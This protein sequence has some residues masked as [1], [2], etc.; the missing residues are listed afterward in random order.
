MVDSTEKTPVFVILGATGSV[1]GELTR[2]LSASGARLMLG[3]RDANALINAGETFSSPV[4]NIDAHAPETIE[5]CI[6]TA[7]N[8]YGRIDGIVNC[9][10]SLIL[11]SAHATSYQ[12]WQET[13][14]V[15]L[16]SAFA[17]VRMAGKLM[18]QTGG[19][20]ILIS[21]AAART[22]LANHEAIAAAKAGVI[23]LTLSAAATYA[24][25]GIR[26]NAIAPGLIKS[27]MTRKIWEN[28]SA[29]SASIAMH[30]LQR[31]GEPRDVASLIEWLLQPENNWITGQIIGVDGG[32]SSIVQKQKNSI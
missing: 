11:K 28:L 12:E 1:G 8:S 22:G 2:R 17:A 27:N 30:P 29:E 23:G 20:V 16:N 3:G 14:T 18:R 10:G 19:S 4:H 21:S 13:I 32:L 7:Y 6:E 26:I 31:L 15:N 24:C 9:I 25:R 5:D